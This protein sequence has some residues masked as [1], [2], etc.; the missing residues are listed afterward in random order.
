MENATGQKMKFE[1]LGTTKVLFD[2][3]HHLNGETP[4]CFWIFSRTWQVATLS[5]V[6][7]RP[8]VLQPMNVHYSPA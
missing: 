7:G 2:S 6:I 4:E 5:L 8:I 3:R 1:F